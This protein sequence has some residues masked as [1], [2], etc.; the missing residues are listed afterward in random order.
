MEFQTLAGL[1]HTLQT[2]A[3]AALIFALCTYLPTLKYKAHLAK[4]PLFNGSETG[5]KQRQTY[6]TSAKTLYK[7]GYA[8]VGIAPVLFQDIAKLL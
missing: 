6:L 7:E 2:A 1:S 3:V 8:K 4:L 5:E